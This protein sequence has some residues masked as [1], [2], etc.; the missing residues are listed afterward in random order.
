MTL[1]QLRIFVVVADLEHVTRAAETLNLT[2]SATSAAIAAL[3]AQHGLMLFQRVG[4]GIELTASGRIF[5]AEAKAVLAR[6]KSA[7]L[8]LADLAGLKRGTLAIQASQTIAGYWL[9]ARMV[10]FKR[11]YP[12]INVELAVGNTEQAAKAVTEG[13]AELGFLEGVV[14]DEELL[15]EVVGRDRLIIVTGA[16]QP[17]GR[18]ETLSPHDLL[19]TD[20]VLR[21]QGSGTRSVFETAVRAF[22]LDPAQLNVVLTLPSNESVCAAVEAGAGAT[23]I[24]EW[25]AGHGLQSG[26]LRRAGLDLPSR[27]FYAIRHRG[28]KQSQAAL[29][30]MRIAAEAPPP[31]RLAAAR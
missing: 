17:W 21:E 16:A 3:E 13:A 26:S 31:P 30:F 19:A 27:A 7:E 2:Q 5:L 20:W 4:R 1:D 10:D 22:G 18:G 24:S 23:A 28:R 25:V 14:D 12:G 15:Q 6:A 8:M 11:A 29:A 9:P